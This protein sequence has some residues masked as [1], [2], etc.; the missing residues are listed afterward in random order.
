MIEVPSVEY[1]GRVIRD[2]YS[3]WPSIRA[4]A[5]RRRGRRVGRRCGTCVAPP[6][7]VILRAWHPALTRWANVWRAYGAR[8]GRSLPE[9]RHGGRA[10]NAMVA[11]RR[12]NA[13]AATGD[14]F[15]RSGTL[16]QGVLFW[17]LTRRLLVW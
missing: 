13:A 4:K 17:F 15:E 1:Y 12:M 8:D 9:A 14:A 3:E 2:G 7:L 16:G 6:V 11:S 10:A 5:T